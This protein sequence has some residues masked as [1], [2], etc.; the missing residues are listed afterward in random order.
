MV[1]AMF[2]P[3]ALC[4]RTQ[5]RGG[6]YLYM[7]EMMAN[8]QALIQK[9]NKLKKRFGSSFGQVFFGKSTHKREFSST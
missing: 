7:K 8:F 2:E 3:L 9:M 4:C 6:L 1:E 5:L